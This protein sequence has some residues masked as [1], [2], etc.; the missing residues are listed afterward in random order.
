[1]IKMK[2]AT[3]LKWYTTIQKDLK[4]FLYCF[5]HF[6][7]KSDTKNLITSDLK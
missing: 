2:Y 4:I 6:T 1:M 7:N 3:V 5:L